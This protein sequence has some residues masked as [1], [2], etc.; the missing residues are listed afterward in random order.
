MTSPPPA[1]VDFLHDAIRAGYVE[2][3]VFL[4]RD[5]IER[6]DFFTLKPFVLGSG[7]RR[8]VIDEIGEPCLFGGWQYTEE[9]RKELDRRSLAAMFKAMK[10][11][12]VAEKD[13]TGEYR[14]LR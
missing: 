8:M 12:A 7:S 9:G 10:E 6:N 1:S 13:R 2:E 5:G 14:F 3:R 11:L 4:D